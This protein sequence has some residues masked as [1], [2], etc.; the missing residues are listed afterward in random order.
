[1]CSTNY[2]NTDLLKFKPSYTE[3]IETSTRKLRET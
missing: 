1:M 2:Q 3:K